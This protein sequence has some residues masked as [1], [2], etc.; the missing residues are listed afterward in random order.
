MATKRKLPSTSENYEEQNAA[1]YSSSSTT[2]PP[3]SRL[4]ASEKT[5]KLFEGGITPK[6]ILEDDLITG[7]ILA[8]IQSDECPDYMKEEYNQAKLLSQMPKNLFEKGN[9]LDSA[10]QGYPLAL[11]IMTNNYAFGKGGYKT[12]KTKAY[13][14]AVKAAEAGDSRGQFYLGY[15]YNHG[16]VVPVN[17]GTALDWYKRCEDNAKALNNIGIIYY[18]IDKDYKKAVEYYQ[19]AADKGDA[20]GQFNLAAMYYRGEG[21]KKSYDDA[22][23]FYKMSADQ[24][25]DDALFELGK[26]LLKGE[27]G[28]KRFVDG[29]SLV[30]QSSALGNETAKMY[31][32]KTDEFFKRLN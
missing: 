5:K 16:F 32:K 22:R 2:S 11:G 10:L 15:S 26:M 13:E 9:I 6:D 20:V 25:D 30:E 17:Y 24:N 21:V 4:S 8:Y 19:K 18:D 3:T 29:Y 27:G 1:S 23:Q 12:N 28:A 31:L 14:F 7:E